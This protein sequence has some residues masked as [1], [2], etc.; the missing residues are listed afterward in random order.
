MSNDRTPPT[1]ASSNMRENLQS[2]DLIDPISGKHIFSRKKVEGRIDIVLESR[3]SI[4][5]GRDEAQILL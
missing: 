2:A 3:G 1:A 5:S 4:F